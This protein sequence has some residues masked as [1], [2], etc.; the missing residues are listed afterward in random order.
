MS[1]QEDSEEE[2]KEKVKKWVPS[3]KCA[4][5]NHTDMLC[6]I[7]LDINCTKE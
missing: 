7:C 4:I 1:Y 5:S 6:S 3:L 2:L